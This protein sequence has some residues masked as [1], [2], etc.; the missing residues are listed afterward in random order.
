MP[1]ITRHNDGKSTVSVKLPFQVPTKA[2]IK[3][4]IASA[5]EAIATAA[6]VVVGK[7][8]NSA[9]AETAGA[10]AGTVA[11]KFDLFKSAFATARAN[12]SA[13]KQDVE[14]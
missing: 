4:V 10:I 14:S 2:K 11:G 1:K 7:T 8:E 6:G 13:P 12:A 5:P 3:S 9:V